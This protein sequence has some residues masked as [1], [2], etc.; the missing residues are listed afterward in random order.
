VQNTK[1]LQDVWQPLKEGI[2]KDYEGDD[3]KREKP[4]HYQIEGLPK[5]HYITHILYD[6]MNHLYTKSIKVWNLVAFFKE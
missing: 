1:E 6:T 4:D 2:L 3:Q 5:S